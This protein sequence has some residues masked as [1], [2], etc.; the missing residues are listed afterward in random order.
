MVS[1]VTALYTKAI[2]LDPTN[3]VLLSNR[4]AALLKLKKVTKAL[5]D[6]EECIR[7]SP[8]WEKGYFR[9]AAVLEE[10][11]NFEQV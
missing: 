8:D 2:K 4:S 9:K 5:E 7:I 3:A 1:S 6:A 10:M 11:E